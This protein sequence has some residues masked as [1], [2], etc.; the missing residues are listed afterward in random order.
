MQ[1]TFTGQHLHLLLLYFPELLLSFLAPH[2]SRPDMDLCLQPNSIHVIERCERIRRRREH[3]DPNW[4]TVMTSLGVEPHYFWHSVFEAKQQVRSKFVSRMRNAFIDAEAREDEVD[5][6]RAIDGVETEALWLS[7]YDTPR[8]ARK[9]LKAA[10]KIKNVTVAER[11]F[12]LKTLQC[13]Q[14]LVWIFFSH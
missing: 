7:I 14:K 9:I 5:S 13:I 2:P 8:F 10:L 11:I 3:S 12:Q 4:S 1:F 6:V